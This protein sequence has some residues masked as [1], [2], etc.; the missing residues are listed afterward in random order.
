MGYLVISITLSSDSANYFG[1]SYAANFRRDLALGP[2]IFT[3]VSNLLFPL[4]SFNLLK[5]TEFLNPIWIDI[6]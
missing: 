4:I 5:L 2:I 1:L 6:S 3:G